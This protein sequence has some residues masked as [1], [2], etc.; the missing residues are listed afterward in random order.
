MSDLERDRLIRIEEITR[1][2]RYVWLQNDQLR[3]GQLLENLMGC[4]CIFYRTDEEF[5]K[6][7]KVAM[8]IGVLDVKPESS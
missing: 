5:A 3:L 6:A 2:L 1:N 4:N 7:L 8:E